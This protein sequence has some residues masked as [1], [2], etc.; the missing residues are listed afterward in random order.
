MPQW[1]CTMCICCWQN[2][3]DDITWLKCWHLLWQCCNSLPE[4]SK[5]LHMILYPLCFFC[6]L[7][8]YQIMQVSGKAFQACLRD[9]KI[10]FNIHGV[11]FYRKKVVFLFSCKILACALIIFASCNCLLDH[12]SCECWSLL[13]AL[14]LGFAISWG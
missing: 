3:R 12:G 11:A 4:T 13:L 8:C 6:L 10:P 7:M 1:R 5:L 9:R 2:F 14:I